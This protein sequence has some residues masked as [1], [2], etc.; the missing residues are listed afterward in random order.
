ML[1]KPCVQKI[2]DQSTPFKTNDSWAI[3]VSRNDGPIP[4]RRKYGEKLW[5]YRYNIKDVRVVGA[6]SLSP[7]TQKVRAANTSSISVELVGY[8]ERMR[9]RMGYYARMCNVSTPILV[10]K[11]CIHV[12]GNFFVF[13]FNSSATI[14]STWRFADNNGTRSIDPSGTDVTISL[15]EESYRGLPP[16]SQYGSIKNEIYKWGRPL[17]NSRLQLKWA[18]ILKPLTVSKLK[19]LYRDTFDATVRDNFSKAFRNYFL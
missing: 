8:W 14:V 11:I 1:L 4:V 18:E 5:G 16:D 10:E 7:R 17:V 12:S 2:V 6:S 3:H 9:V 15:A 13:L 19:R